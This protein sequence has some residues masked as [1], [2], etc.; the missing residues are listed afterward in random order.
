MMFLFYRYVVFS[1]L[2]DLRETVVSGCESDFHHEV[3][4]IDL[5][6]PIMSRK[7]IDCFCPCGPWFVISKN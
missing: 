6:T 7:C 5:R 4:L 2:I 3:F 1:L